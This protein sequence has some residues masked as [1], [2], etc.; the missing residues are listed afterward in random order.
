MAKMLIVAEKPSVAGDIAKALGG[1]RKS[2]GYYERHDAIVSHA[3]GHLVQIHAPE[4]DERTYD[5]KK[6]PI[7]PFQFGLEV[8]Q[9]RAGDFSV[10]KKLMERSDVG[11]VVNA[12]DAGREGE[13]I[14]RYVV[15][16][17]KC[18]KPMQRM[19]IQSMTESAIVE[20]FN[21]RKPGVEFDA[22]A[23][24]AMCRSESDFLVGI[25]G[26]RGVTLFRTRQAGQYESRPV[27]RVMTP[28]LAM[29][30]R[31]ERELANFVAK[32]YWEVHARFGVN[33]GEFA[34]RWK[35][36]E[37]EQKQPGQEQD[38]ED[39]KFRFTKREDADA[40]VGKCAGVD[41]T[42][43]I[44][45]STEMQSSA[46]APFD[47][48]TLQR[49]A[50]EKLGFS[51]AKT[52]ELAQQLYEMKLITYP[53]TDSS[54]LPEDYVNQAKQVL[55]ALQAQYGAAATAPLLN[56]WVNDKCKVFDNS[57]ISDHFAITPTGVRPSGLSGDAK[58]LY[59]MVSQRFMATFH[60][61]AM[62]LKTV[63]VVIVAGEQFIGTG[64]VLKKAGWKSVYGVSAESGE[65]GPSSL[66]ALA[67]GEKGKTLEVSRKDLKTKP[68]KR[69]TE[70]TLLGA[71]EAAG[72][73]VD[74]DELRAVMKDKGL[75]T[76]AT[77]AATIEK[78]LDAKKD[79]EA[80]VRREGKYLVPNDSAMTLITLLEELGLEILTEAK[81]TGEWEH[82]LKQMEKKGYTRG[83]FMQEIGQ[84]TRDLIDRISKRADTL[85]PSTVTG[86]GH[87]A[88]DM[89]MCPKCSK[90]T[91]RRIKGKFG[92]FW[93][94]ADR[95]CNHTMK[96]DNGTPVEKTSGNADAPAAPK[97]K[98]GEVCPTCKT[99][100]L[101]EQRM[102]G[103][104]GKAFIGCTG[105]PKCRF[106]GWP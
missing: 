104:G 34:A 29:L 50:N 69:F 37:V 87:Q 103:K 70:A 92:F 46:P 5:I 28:T 8:I 99:G 84:A 38:D 85:P 47:L 105:Y 82:K 95:E 43:I 56:G 39:N 19:W 31:R 79:Q 60:P 80:Y 74:D 14:F 12:C 68:P 91:L 65:D 86:G 41:P 51:A 15:N 106:F 23:D 73:L 90:N 18:G 97:H 98:A 20:A 44:D 62:Y 17:A 88:A 22:L 52:L 57:K 55:E 96:D 48:T 81:T 71:M 27:G 24:A 35:R 33:A 9:Q 61:P 76:P 32:D 72:K 30:V 59:D 7:I 53:R 11:S 1:F 42:S 77:R 66:C 58:A 4:F 25:N 6:L 3:R 100:T 36:R 49:E 67:P 64:S 102:P 93:G 16:K 101:R 2:D 21:S 63:R 83:K 10:L 40:I 78:L 89:K 94:C 75:G 45:E 13:L 26:S 54:S